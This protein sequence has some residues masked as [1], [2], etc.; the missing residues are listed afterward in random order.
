MMGIFDCCNK[1]SIC[2]E[3]EENVKF[4]FYE[5]T[6]KSRREIKLHDYDTFEWCS[7]DPICRLF[8]A[9]IFRV[10]LFYF[11]EKFVYV[12]LARNSIDITDEAK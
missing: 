1:L 5:L 7:T 12:R 11:A 8:F 10:V 3:K 2:I 9:Y 6:Q 4:I